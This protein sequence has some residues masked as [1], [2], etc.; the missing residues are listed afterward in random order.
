M[1]EKR[2]KNFLDTLS[3]FFCMEDF[4]NNE[5]FIDL[6]KVA[7]LKHQP[8]MVENSIHF[9]NRGLVGQFVM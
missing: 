4:C 9:V 3:I 7:C 2:K 1:N 5:N 6:E 8:K